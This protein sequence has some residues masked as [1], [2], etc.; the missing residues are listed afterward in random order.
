MPLVRWIIP[1][2]DP[3]WRDECWATLHPDIRKRTTI[4][5]NGAHNCG[6]ATSWNLGA[7]Q[8]EKEGA[9]WMVICS[10]TMRFGAPGGTD[11]EDR[12]VGPWA[13]CGHN[14]HLIAFSVETLME[15]GPFDE[16]FWPIYFEDADYERRL[17]LAGMPS[18]RGEQ[19]SVP[20]MV[21]VDA[22]AEASGHSLTAGLVSVNMGIQAARYAT[23]WGGPKGSEKYTTP[24]GNPDLTIRDVTIGEDHLA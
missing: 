13:D 20:P 6:V 3:V 24:Y 9:R 10:E 4:I 17:T 8:A 16:A 18:P 7:V 12:L 11:F 23:K 19:R 14:W 15:V 1:S 21:G 22:H 2:I 5:D